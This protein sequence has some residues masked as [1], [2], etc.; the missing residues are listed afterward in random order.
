MRRDHRRALLRDDVGDLRVVSELGEP[1]GVAGRFVDRQGETALT[2]GLTTRAVPI[3]DELRRVMPVLHAGFAARRRVH[4]VVRDDDARHERV[5]NVA[6]DPLEPVP[7]GFERAPL[8]DER[9]VE[10]AEVELVHVPTERLARADA[11]RERLTGRD[12]IVRVVLEHDVVGIARRADDLAVERAAYSAP[13]VFR[14]DA[15]AGLAEML[16][17][18]GHESREGGLPD[19]RAAMVTREPLPHL[20]ELRTRPGAGRDRDGRHG[21]IVRE[22]LTLQRVAQRRDLGDERLRRAREVEL[23]DR[24]RARGRLHGSCIMAFVAPRTPS[25]SA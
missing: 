11:A 17:R 10:L 18:I 16:V 12:A 21:R 9:A 2:P 24:E 15:H 8:A 4:R 6:V 13:A 14:Q 22:V 23:L 19:H 20:E 1:G 25:I 3:A 7:R 5:G